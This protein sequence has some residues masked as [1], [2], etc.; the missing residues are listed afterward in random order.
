MGQG[1]R[2]ERHL[3]S[4]LR[5]RVTKNMLVCCLGFGINERIRFAF[6]EDVRKCLC[7]G[8]RV[9]LTDDFNIATYSGLLN[10]KITLK[11]KNNPCLFL[12]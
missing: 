12:Q 8:D 5:M 3:C 10:S 11:K 9:A 4:P 2:V 1:Q 7:A 6:I